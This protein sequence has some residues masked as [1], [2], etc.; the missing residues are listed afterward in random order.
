MAQKLRE[1]EQQRRAKEVA[2]PKPRAHVHSN[3]YSRDTF[4]LEK[5]IREGMEFRE[6]VYSHCWT[7]GS[8][9][10]S[11][12]EHFAQ[13]LIA[14]KRLQLRGEWNFLTLNQDMRKLMGDQVV[15]AMLPYDDQKDEKLRSLITN[16]K[17]KDVIHFLRHIHMCV[18]C[19]DKHGVRDRLE[20]LIPKPTGEQLEAM[21]PLVAAIDPLLEELAE[22]KENQS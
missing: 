22:K 10:I 4:S 6:W 16:R 7:C 14:S 5:A 17:V 3:S 21:M 9:G 15:L 18:T 19:V 1:E 2:K 11:L 12:R 13:C 20:A 8:E